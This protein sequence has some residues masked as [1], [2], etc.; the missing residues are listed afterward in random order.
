MLGILWPESDPERARH[1]LSQTLYNLRRDLGAEVVLSTPDLRLDSQQISSD[2]DDFRSAVRARE[3]RGAAALYVGPFLDGFYLAEAPEFERW[4]ATERSALATDGMRAIEVLARESEAAGKREEAAEYWRRLTRLDP[5]SARYASAYMEALAAIGD[6]AGALGHGKEHADLLRREFEAEPDRKVA[7]LLARLRSAESST[8]GEVAAPQ[9]GVAKAEAPIGDSAS[10]AG[11]SSPMA[12]P[13]EATP[14]ETTA[15]PRVIPGARRRRNRV[16]LAVGGMLAVAAVATLAWRAGSASRGGGPVLA[17]GRIRDLVTPDSLALGGV[18]SEMLA[19][20]LTRLSDLQVIANSRM[21]ELTPRNAD[22]SRGVVSD[23]AARAGATE[24]IE[25]EVRPLPNHQL[26]LE[27]RRVDIARG[28]VRR[29]YR[30]TGGD[31]LALFDSVT[32]LIAADLRVR[33]PTGSLAEISTRSPIAYRL[34][35]EGLREFYQFDGFTAA[36]LFRSALREDSTF[37]M[38]AYYAWRAG[39]LTND[40]AQ[41]ALARRAV[42]LAS[43]ASERDRLLILTNI[44]HGQSDPR[45]LAAA[46]TLATRYQ[47]DPE[48]LLHAGEV[49]RDLPRATALLNRVIALDSA[50]GVQPAAVC[51]LCDAMRIL[52]YRYSWADSI[53][54][55]L[56]TVERW[57][58][59]RPQDYVAWYI[60]ADQLIALGR[61]AEA[62]AALR[63]AQSLGTLREDALA[64]SL[65]WSLRS[66]DVDGMN[67]QCD[68][69]LAVRDTSE[70]VDFRWYC[71]IGLRMQ[72]RYREAR[73]LNHEGR[74]PSTGARWRGAPLDPYNIA[75]LDLEMDRPLAAADTFLALGRRAAAAP[76]IPD[77]VRARTAGWMYTLAA[78]AAVA[79]G[80]TA[81]ARRMVDTIEATGRRSAYDRDPVLHHFVRG[82]LHSSA[83]RHEP[84]VREFQAAMTSPT[85]GYTRINYEL[86]KS[87]LALGRARDAIPILRAP[88]RGGIEGSGLYLTRTE[89]HELLARAFDAAGEPDSAAAH[90]AIVARAWRAADP[91]L[92]PRYEAARSWIALRGHPRQEQV[93]SDP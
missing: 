49:I 64:R 17:V 55:A 12:V 41:E 58:V 14:H 50:A 31:R 59:L 68:T 72:G 81:R 3:W 45:A 91:F 75:I 7:Q 85:N 5:V 18:L 34:Y 90:Y 93:R 37:A 33:P 51:H 23:A 43:R 83:G 32:S 69:V 63:R 87:L 30:V 21:L 66:D 71:T 22:T 38:A 60:R 2:I 6:R 84:A 26:M 8:Q 78:T 4:A 65:V 48:V 10:F 36:R 24:I 27:V 76:D 70:F 25:G 47:Y 46:E 79:G 80:D 11:T 29:G 82:L 89:I 39:I 67:A 13:D 1:V 52:A 28:L 56:R 61:R 54:A 16:L 53:D 35:E 9:Q 74:V 77:G 42:A 62:L 44:G 73:A 15:A 92:K 19:T 86:G 57:S 20:S 40:P 88:L